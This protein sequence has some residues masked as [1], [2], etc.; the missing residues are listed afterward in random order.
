MRTADLLID[1]FQR[2]HGVVHG[3]LDGASSATVT[4]RPASEANTIA[5]LVWHLTRV[6]DDH[7]SEVAKT[8]QVWTAEGFYDR[9][10]LPFGV[11]ATGYGHGSA[12]VAAVTAGAELLGAYFDA[13]QD[14]TQAYLA[15]L[16][17]ADLDRIVDDRWTPP[18]SLGMRL[19]SVLSDDL[20]HAGQAAYLRGLTG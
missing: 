1:G 13:V 6:Q 16:D 5:W 9:F 14:R 10:G 17:D 8:E 20:Q 3:A 7:V 18:V 11:A 4:Y 2:I 15:T 12:D 19:I